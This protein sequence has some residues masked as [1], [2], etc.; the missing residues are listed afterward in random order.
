METVSEPPKRPLV[1]DYFQPEMVSRVRQEHTFL[2]I[3]RQEMDARGWDEAD[4]VFVTGDA[5]VDHPSFAA[6]LLGRVLE[7]A[8]Y[9]TALLCQP[10]WHSCEDW[11]TF[12]R[13]KLAF[14]ISAGN[15]DS[16]ISNYTAGRK[17]RNDDAYSPNGGSGRRPDRAT[18]SYCQRAREAFPGITILTGGVEASLRRMAHYDFWSD[19]VKRSILMDSKADILFY[20]MGEAPLLEVLRRLA[21]GEPVQQIRDVRGTVYR[22]GASEDLPEEDEQTV[23]LPSYEE[24][25]ES[26][27]FFCEMTRIAYQNLNPYCA[28]RLIQEHCQ[29]AVVINPPSLPL[30]TP[31]L[32]AVYGLPFRRMP[33]PSYGDAVIPAYDV[34][35]SSIQIH[36]G[37]F[38][39]CAF[40]SLAAHQGKFIQS[41][42]QD[43]ILQEVN[44]LQEKPDYTGTISDLGGPTANMYTLGGKAEQVCAVCRKTSCLVPEICENLETSHRKIIGLMRAVR[45]SPS[46]R[47]VF[48]ASGVRTDLALCSPEY[49]T[50]LVTH[51]VGGHLKT[52]PEHVDP[53]VLKLMQKPSIEN[54]DA[55][56]AMFQSV[57]GRNHKDLY[58]VP[59]LIAGLPGSDIPAM[60]RV[61]E[62]LHKHLIQP[63][64]VQDFIPGPFEL[65]TCMYYTGKNPLTGEAVHVARG[66]RERRI[67]RALLQYF[68]PENYYDVKMA[69]RDFDRSDLIGNGP[70]CL[71]PPHPP[72]GMAMNQSSRVKRLKR[73]EDREKA[74]RT[75]FR[76]EKER[77]N[78]ERHRQKTDKRREERPGGHDAERRHEQSS[79]QR[80][81]RRRE[82]RYNNER[83]SDRRREERAGGHDAERR[84]E[85]SSEQRSEQR[86]EGRYNNERS[87]D[88]PRERREERPGGHDAERRHERSS[89]Q[90][91]ERRREGRYNN[92]R[93]SDRP[94]ERREERP[95]GH[96]AERRHEQSGEQRPERRRE[97]RYNNDRNSDRPRERRE[98]RSED[99]TPRKSQSRNS[100]TGK[101][102]GTPF[103]QSTDKPSGKF[104]QRPFTPKRSF[105]KK[106]PER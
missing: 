27:D 41:R 91:P 10:D 38:G 29:E 100:A 65:A 52:A 68:K 37:C 57:C 54:Y 73:K 72:R 83:S 70:D 98:G 95:G 101:P 23:H 13:P 30:T 6:A 84:H 40:C 28:A 22:L 12:G 105:G 50:E 19:K 2:P 15:M 60:I 48:I 66:M 55:F 31:E 61:A 58:L 63:Q 86:R 24:I 14:C 25:A 75:A 93:N 74:Q 81:E 7:A 32:D 62:Y 96:D 43:S 56:A 5:Y 90:R 99:R 104:S 17:V 4:I 47:Q 106:R 33:H 53:H 20:G 102:S 18:L 1:T 9:R 71:I 82:G 87:S 92:E 45:E 11:K 97:G 35:K 80:P 79:E 21:E 76:E 69:L 51:H 34:I 89:E 59:Y 78:L 46:V 88:R 49:L 103:G 39:G 36:R 44:Q 3:T 85:R 8:G 77:E 16:M 94:R 42:S 64:Q 26:K 67:Q